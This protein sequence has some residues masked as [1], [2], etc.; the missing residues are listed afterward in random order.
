MEKLLFKI[1]LLNVVL[2]SI[3]CDPIRRDND[4]DD[5]NG[6]DNGH[7]SNQQAADKPIT[8]NQTT[9]GNKI[10]QDNKGNNNHHDSNA[11]DNQMRLAMKNYQNSQHLP[12]CILKTADFYLWWLNEDGTLN[13]EQ[14]SRKYIH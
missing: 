11:M 12:E 8:I 3:Y 14:T 7:K 1:V 9:S 10:Q 2:L 4:V 5:D 6:Y 13:F